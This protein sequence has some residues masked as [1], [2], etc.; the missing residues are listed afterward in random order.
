MKILDVGSSFGMPV[1]SIF[2]NP[3]LLVSNGYQEIYE[4]IPGADLVMFGGGEDVHPMLYGHQN[5]GSYCGRAPSYRD[6]VEREI[7]N[8]C[9]ELKKPMLGICRGAQLLCALSGGFLIQDVDGHAVG[10]NGH[11][12][13]TSD[14]L[15]MSMSSTHHQMM[16]PFQTQHKLLAWSP[17]R[18]RNYRFDQGSLKANF[19]FDPKFSDPEIVYFPK[20]KSLAIQGHP[21]YYDDLDCPPV[22]L[23]RDLAQQYLFDGKELP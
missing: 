7:F 12:I 22:K 15:E 14:G 5:V 9:V 11:T 10:I 16:Y 6:L 8:R 21:E 1:A 19:I 17:K 23:S 20:T 18:S 2:R 3:T 4:N 13:K